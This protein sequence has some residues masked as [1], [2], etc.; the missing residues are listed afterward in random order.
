[1]LPSTA[2]LSGLDEALQ[3]ATQSRAPVGAV[4]EQLKTDIG[5]ELDAA[6]A[7]YTEARYHV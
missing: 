2:V 7:L 1:M 3:K 4:R 6:E 5:A